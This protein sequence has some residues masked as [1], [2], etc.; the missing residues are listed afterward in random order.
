MARTQTRAP[1]S[2]RRARETQRRLVR[3]SRSARAH[4]A[5]TVG[6]G[7]LA[8][9]L[10]IAQATLLAVVIAGVF[11]DGDS[12]ADVSGLLVW[13]GLIAVARGVVG[14]GFESSGRFGAS[15]VMSELRR[16]LGASAAGESGHG[17]R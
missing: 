17:P 10:I 4:I 12:F 14:A 16:S 6:L 3:S 5:L 1:D 2:S 13:L 7:F 9:A 8:T 15:R 11:M